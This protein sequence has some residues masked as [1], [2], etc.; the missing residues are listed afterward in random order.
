MEGLEGF[1]LRLR[2]SMGN[3][4]DKQKKRELEA[5]FIL[6]RVGIIMQCLKSYQHSSLSTLIQL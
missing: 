2:V 5:R 4:K 3:H 6:G 1:G